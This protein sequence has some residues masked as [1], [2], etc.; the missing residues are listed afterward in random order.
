[1]SKGKPAI[2]LSEGRDSAIYIDKKILAQYLEQT[3]QEI[4]W[5]VLGEKQKL[6]DIGFR[7]FPGRSEFSY[8]YSLNEGKIVR[9]HEVFNTLEARDSF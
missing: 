7:N 4:V 6:G 5:T 9:N 1:M 8:S 2:Y 3:G